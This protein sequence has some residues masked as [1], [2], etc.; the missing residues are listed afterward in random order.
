M[1]FVQLRNIFMRTKLKQNDIKLRLFLAKKI[2]LFCNAKGVFSIPN[3]P[4]NHPPHSD[5][6][7][8]AEFSLDFLDSISANEIFYTELAKKDNIY[9]LEDLKQ[10][11]ERF[12]KT[13]NLL[14]HRNQFLKESS[15]T[16]NTDKPGQI[17]N[18]GIQRNK[19]NFHNHNKGNQNTQNKM[20]AQNQNQKQDEKPKNNFLKIKI[21]IKKK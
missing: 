10:F 2:D 6:P 17:Q 21:L 4:P 7:L 8:F 19:P 16:F 12:E 14:R 1:N 20:N 3:D 15:K 18:F 9:N 5:N 13:C 11:V